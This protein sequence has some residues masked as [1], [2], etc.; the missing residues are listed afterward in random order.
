[1]RFGLPQN[2]LSR[3]I[4]STNDVVIHRTGASETARSWGSFVDVT[5]V[6][7]KEESERRPLLS[8]QLRES[9]LAGHYFSINS[10]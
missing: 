8:S 3:I 2:P 9:E 4:S 6:I 10:V 7:D 1:M 5:W